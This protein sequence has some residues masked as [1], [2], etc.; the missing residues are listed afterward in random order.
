MSHSSPS[1]AVIAAVLAERP[2]LAVSVAEKT[3]PL[4]PY[5]AA[6]RGL[7]LASA[8]LPHPSS[9]STSPLSTSASPA[10][11]RSAA[12]VVLAAWEPPSKRSRKALHATPLTSHW[13][14]SVASAAVEWGSGGHSPASTASTS[15]QSS[16]PLSALPF[17]ASHAHSLDRRSSF[18]LSSF[19]AS[20]VA[21]SVQPPPLRISSAPPQS[22]TLSGAG[23]QGNLHARLQ[24]HPAIQLIQQRLR[25]AEQQRSLSDEDDEEEEEDAASDDDSDCAHGSSLSYPEAVDESKAQRLAASDRQQPYGAPLSQV[26]PLQSP[27]SSSFA[28][29]TLSPSFHPSAPSADATSGAVHLPL[30]HVSSVSTS[31]FYSRDAASDAALGFVAGPLPRSVYGEWGWDTEAFPAASSEEEPWQG[32][33]DLEQPYGLTRDNRR[34]SLCTF[35]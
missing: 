22:R 3:S 7:V 11:I 13:T 23:S 17:S 1:Q 29:S 5:P 32:W 21:R 35:Y 2:L 15:S 33:L 20:S 34:S 16:A 9:S 27:T 14:D 31:S 18:P 24:Q 12:A 8:A 28:R 19:P 10:R 25:G 30:S 6:L 4:P 26:D